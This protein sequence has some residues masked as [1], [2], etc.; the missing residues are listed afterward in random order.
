MA[1]KDKDV[2][3]VEENHN[4]PQIH[5]KEKKKF[6][7]GWTPEQEKLMAEWADIAMCYRWLHDRAE[8]HYKYANYSIQIP[9]IILSTLT[10]TASVGIS[11]I[12]GDNMDLQ[13]YC[14]FAIGGVS[15]ITGILSTLG[16]YLRF[17]QLQESNR[18]AAVSWSKFHRMI[19]TELA[20]HPDRR[21]DCQDFLKICRSDL[22]RMLENAPELHT[23]AINDFN[24]RIG[25]IKEF[26]IPDVVN[27]LNKTEIYNNDNLRLKQLA[28]ETALVINS[29]KELWHDLE[30]SPADIKLYERIEKRL[31]TMRAEEYGDIGKINLILSER[32]SALVSP[33][34]KSP[35]VENQANALTNTIVE[36]KPYAS[37]TFSI[38]PAKNEI[39]TKK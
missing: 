34:P 1:D 16:S 22:D 37:Q 31:K 21:H 13:K 17:A 35:M 4:E 24:K 19:R 33:T 2:S 29:K 15:I 7:N 10:G 36:I 20:L 32:S 26:K 9:V 6:M 28:L 5:K 38:K 11:S 3:D 39:V 23:I 18:N 25:S 12:V 14:Q 27:N 8:K 30:F